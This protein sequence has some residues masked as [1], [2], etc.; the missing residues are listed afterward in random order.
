MA[1][2]FGLLPR[3]H[4]RRDLAAQ[5]VYPLMQVM[6]LLRRVLMLAGNRLHVRDLLLYAFEF[7]LRF[8]A[9]SV[10]GC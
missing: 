9:A 2:E 3:I 8:A 10:H 6:E 4:V 7:L 1:G 5:R